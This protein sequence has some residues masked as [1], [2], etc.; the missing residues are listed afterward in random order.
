MSCPLPQAW[1]AEG[2]VAFCSIHLFLDSRGV[3]GLRGSL[4]ALQCWGNAYSSHHALRRPLLP[5]STS[6]CPSVP[7]L[8]H[9]AISGQRAVGG[10]AGGELTF[11]LEMLAQEEG[12]FFDG[13]GYITF[14]LPRSSPHANVHSN[15]IG[16]P[17]PP[18]CCLVDF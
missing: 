9:P 18:T 3:S 14:F 17:S 1:P 5:T 11:S 12:S 15:L 8:V 7:P 4:V 16:P 2:R 13:V 10:E 6:K